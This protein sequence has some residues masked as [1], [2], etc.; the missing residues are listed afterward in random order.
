MD[1]LHSPHVT[2]YLVYFSPSLPMCSRPLKKSLQM[3]LQ[4]RAFSS[5]IF[6]ITKN[7]G[8]WELSS[9]FV[10]K[11]FCRVK[12]R[13]Y[14]DVQKTLYLLPRSDFP[15]FYSLFNQNIFFPPNSNLLY[16]FVIYLGIFFLRFFL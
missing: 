10:H 5:W 2:A 13:F 3:N 4:S 11:M 7:W 12:G 8:Q 1:G 14:L 16:S 15:G 9:D 6:E